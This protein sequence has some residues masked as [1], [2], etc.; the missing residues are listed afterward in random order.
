[1]VENVELSSSMTRSP[2]FISAPSGAIH[3]IV[4]CHCGKPRY[5]QLFAPSRPQFARNDDV[6]RERAAPHAQRLRIGLGSI[7]R[8]KHPAATRA[9]AQVIKVFMLMRFDV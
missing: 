1:L 5:R 6:T 9:T 3:L 2:C 7:S 4:V 8:E